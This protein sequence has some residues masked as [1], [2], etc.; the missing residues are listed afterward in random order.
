MV[1]ERKSNFGRNGVVVFGGYRRLLQR[2]SNL[3]CGMFG[4]VGQRFVDGE[5]VANGYG[6]RGHSH[7]VLSGWQCGFECGYGSGS[8]LPMA[9]ERSSHFGSHFN[10]LYGHGVGLV[11]CE[12]NFCGGL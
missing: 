11:Q 10:F 2:T 9:A 6:L 1:V 4:D 3:S 5:R 12:S 8:N 7:H